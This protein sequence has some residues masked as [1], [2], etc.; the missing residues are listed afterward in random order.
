MG[1]HSSMDHHKMKGSLGLLL[2]LCLSGS[3]SMSVW[4]DGKEYHFIEESAVHVG[5]NDLASSVS[6]LRMMSEVRIQVTG[7]RLVVSMENVQ[8]AHYS[9][10]YPRG[11]WPYRLVQEG[12]RDQRS[13]YIPSTGYENGNTFS[14]NIEAGLVKSVELPAGASVNA[15]NM[16][17]ALASVLQVDMTGQEMTTWERKEMSI[18]GQC[19]QEYTFLR[20]D[21]DKLM[22][23]SKTVSHIKDCK[24]RNYKIFGNFDAE[25]RNGL[26]DDMCTPVRAMVEESDEVMPDGPKNLYHPE[27]IHSTSMS[28]IQMRELAPQ[29]FKI[30]KIF[31]SGA[32]IVQRFSEEGPTHTTIANRTLTLQEVKNIGQLMEIQDPRT[33]NDLEFEWMEKTTDWNAPIGLDELKKKES[34]YYNGITMDEAQEELVK[35]SKE[36]VRKYVEEMINF[37][38][39]SK[40]KSETIEKLH[41]HGIINILPFL[42]VLNYD[43]LIDLKTHYLTLRKDNQMNKAERDIFLELLPLTGT[44]PSALVVRDLVMNNELHSDMETARMLTSIHFKFQ[45]VKA[46]V[47]EFYKLVTES[48]SKPYLQLPFTKSAVDLSYATL[49]RRTCH[50]LSTQ[51]DCF[52]ALHVGEFIK[53]FEKLA[54]DDHAKLQHLMAVFRN[55]RDSEVLENKL[56]SI[57]LGQSALRYDSA[58]KTQAVFAL[59]E[60]AIRRGK[61]IDYFLPIFLNRNED[62][63]VRLAAFDMLMRSTP[64]ITIFNKIMTH[65]IYETDHE[66][67][68]YVYTA[69]EKFATMHNDPCGHILHDYAQYYIK[70]WKQ[71]MWQKPKYSIGVSKTF[72]NTFVEKKYGYAGAI[73]V[74]TIG[75]HKE[76]TPLSIRIDIKSHR[77]NHVT[78]QDFGVF[79]R[80]EGVA[81]KVVDKIRSMT[82][83]GTLEI[84]KL[85]DILF[86]DMNIRQRSALPAKIC[87]I[88]MRKNTIVFEY[89]LVDSE[90]TDILSK[91]KE[92]VFKIGT[93]Q[94]VF[95]LSKHLGLGWDMFSYEQPTDFGVPMTHGTEAYSVF[96]LLGEAQKESGFTGNLDFRLHMNTENRDAMTVIHPNQKVK[97]TITQDREFKH[98]IKSAINIQLGSLKKT[99]KVAMKVPEKDS[100]FAMLGQS[101]TM[102]ST[103]DNKIVKSHK[104]L[105]E[106]CPTCL[107]EQVVSRGED[108]RKSADI[109]GEYK[110]IGIVYGLDFHGSVFDCEYQKALS[111]GQRLFAALH[112]LN[113]LEKNDK[114]MITV[115]LSGIRQ[116]HS[117]LFY[118]PRVE[119]CGTHLMLSQSTIDPVKEVVFD[120]DLIKFQNLEQPQNLIGEKSISVAGNIIFKGSVERIHQVELEYVLAPMMRK[121]QLDITIRRLQFKLQSKIYPEFPLALHMRTKT[122]PNTVDRQILFKELSSVEKYR[123]HSSMELTWGN[124]DKRIRIAGDHKTTAEGL[125][126]LRTKWYY[127][128]CVRQHSL[129]EW[130]QAEDLPTTDA[131]LYTLQDLFTLRH[132]TWDITAT[133]L[134]PWMVAAYKKIG[135]LLKTS[136]LP[137]WEFSPEYSMHDVS[138][139][140]PNIRIEQIFHPSEQ[141]FDLT[142]RVDKDLSQFRGVNYGLLQLNAEPYMRLDSLPIPF[143]HNSYLRPELLTYMYYNHMI[144]HCHATSKTIRT[145]DNV[146]YPYTMDHSC[147]TLIS[148]DCN[149]QPS[150]AVF[151]RKEKKTPIGLML[152]IGDLKL[153]FVPIKYN[154]FRIYLQGDA[155]LGKQGPFDL[156]DKDSLYW[157]SSEGSKLNTILPNFVFKIIRQQNNFVIDFFPGMMIKYDGNSVQV[158]AGPQVT[159]QHCGMCGD[160]NRNTFHELK[161][162]QMCNLKT[163]EEMARAW[164][165]DKKYCSNPIAKPEC[166]Q[167]LKGY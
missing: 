81:S 7:N 124:Q 23:V 125:N 30:E 100:P 96:G 3:F 144:N 82:T 22:E 117:F 157:S 164:T 122:V 27:P 145:Y 150:F 112:S 49:V 130:R 52:S 131:C 68:N 148:S 24:K 78:V 17:R 32:V 97:F 51:Q 57:I 25:S 4:E 116:I 9:Q 121:S 92:Y 119:S 73:D 166:H 45:P 153:E 26:R 21:E 107:A 91:L 99:I 110:G 67:F 135:S 74:H 152:F 98:Q 143:Y 41:Q 44:W 101:R 46:L 142:L 38:D 50:Q 15:K 69:F 54:V 137:F 8:E 163:G 71:H 20:G 132:H 40:H 154:T 18:H 33:F 95:K 35:V 134:E 10:A 114:N 159:G 48:S 133:N 147:W 123:V 89:H 62:H 84:E 140:Q 11:G 162:P 115:I 86:T 90:I 70:Y 94:E 88:L 34:F 103:S 79:L 104:Y 16:M 42:R 1:T 56:Q 151:I 167:S 139:K 108:Q 129:P 138:P 75:S 61:G 6:G 85:K 43:S 128:T 156:E 5:T 141:S 65:M 149:D 160:Y 146:T 55:F 36:N 28:T 109:I 13:M 120:F 102:I 59:A 158:L 161:D 2:T 76:A 113:P 80:M 66:V 77:Y 37:H 72:T 60:R 29:Q 39:P 83:A 165:L 87:L 64:S 136:L 106:S 127:N 58:L 19:A 155:K 111:P 47:E 14:M 126:H 12:V 31:S 118:F 53:K 63:E 105:A 93:M